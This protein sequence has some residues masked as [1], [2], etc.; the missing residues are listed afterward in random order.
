MTDIVIESCCTSPK[1]A[2]AAQSRGASRIE[3]CVNLAVGGTTPP[4]ELVRQVVHA[5]SIPVNVLIRPRGVALSAQD[6]VYGETDIEEMVREIEMCRHEG[7]A[8]IVV[9]A[10]TG[11]GKIDIEAME[12]LME[13][14]DGLPVTFHRAFDVCR[15]EPPEALEKIIGLHCARLLTSGMAPTAWE[16]R[17]LISRLVARSAGRII[18]MPGSGIKP[19]NL[20]AVREETGAHEFHGTA[21]P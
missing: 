2:F 10:L 7:A 3:L 14:A 13:A 6:F 5:C 1:E 17:E 16:G 15:E 4:R 19:H 11:D 12:R 18:V 8:G 20:E 9:G 21:L